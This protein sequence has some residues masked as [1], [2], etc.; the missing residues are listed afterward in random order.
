MPCVPCGRPT[1]T[2]RL[3]THRQRNDMRP[4]QCLHCKFNRLLMEF[5]MDRLSE[6][7]AKAAGVVARQT[8]RIESKA[9]ALIAREAELEA[10]TDKSFDPH[11]SILDD[12]ERGLDGL[13][14]SWR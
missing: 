5:Q 4:C 11:N 12:A 3:K 1:R 6:K 9:D 8:T 14:E 2:G 10:R 13:I 7:L